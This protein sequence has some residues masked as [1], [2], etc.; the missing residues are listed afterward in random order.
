VDFLSQTPHGCVCVCV[1]MDGCLCPYEGDV[2]VS[3]EVGGR[4][5]VR[6]RG[7]GGAEGERKSG[8]ERDTHARMRA[9]PTIEAALAT[10]CT[11]GVFEERARPTGKGRRSHGQGHVW[12]WSTG[13]S[14]L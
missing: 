14:K 9:F 11:Y 12:T 4:C 6:M 5:G 7:R 3:A 8:S 2:G 13:I 10:R 1:W